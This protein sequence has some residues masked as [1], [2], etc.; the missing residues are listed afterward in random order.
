GSY[1]TGGSSIGWQGAGGTVNITLDMTGLADLMLRMDI[2]SAG[3]GAAPTSFHAVRYRAGQTEQEAGAF[4][5]VPDSVPGFSNNGAFN[6]YQ[7]DLSAL[8]NIDE[9][10]VVQI[11]FEVA[12]IGSGQSLRFDNI[13]FSAGPQGGSEVA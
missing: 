11:Q 13:Q 4:A 1:T 8:S 6:D 7:L 12:Y 10:P 2:R 5:A 3:G 9:M